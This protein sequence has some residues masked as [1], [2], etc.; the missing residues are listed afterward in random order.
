M[1]EKLFIMSAKFWH[2][3]VR[4]SHLQ[5]SKTTF[6]FE[7]V[8]LTLPRIHLLQEDEKKKEAKVERSTTDRVL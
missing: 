4:V 7:K 5:K 6:V 2:Q 8:N 3:D 1:Y